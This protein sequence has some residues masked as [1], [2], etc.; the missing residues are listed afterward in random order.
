MIGVKGE[1][2]MKTMLKKGLPVWL[3]MMIGT[4]IGLLLLLAGV[5][6]LTG[7]VLNESV[8]ENAAGMILLASLLIASFA[9][10]MVSKLMTLEKKAVACFGTGA[11]MLVV[12]FGM[13]FVLFPGAVQGAV[14]TVLL[15]GAGTSLSFF[16]GN[17]KKSMGIKRVKKYRFV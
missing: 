16:V 12:L 14:W 7:M 3:S 13:H 9:G 2:S 15:T 11:A 10:G 6:I 8:S 17:A 1:R 4:G 5:C